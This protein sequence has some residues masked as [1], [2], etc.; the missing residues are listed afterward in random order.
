MAVR[1]RLQ[2]Q[3]KPKRPYYRIVAI[4]QRL[5]R[6]GKPLEI[7]GKY[8]PMATEN[9][10]NVQLDRGSYWLKQG[11]KPSETVAAL[12]KKQQKASA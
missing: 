12:L 5:R 9:K 11:A 8:D 4:D 6:D 3:G 2:R 7:L 10:I 1:I